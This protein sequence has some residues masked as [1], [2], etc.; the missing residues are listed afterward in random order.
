MNGGMRVLGRSAVSMIEIF[1][2]SGKETSHKVVQSVGFTAMARL[3]VVSPSRNSND[4]FSTLL[5]PKQ[6]SVHS[7]TPNV[8]ITG[9]ES[10]KFALLNVKTGEEIENSTRERSAHASSLQLSKDRT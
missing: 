2:Y 9:H 5:D 8:I 4:D 7:L 10:G 3:E 1:R 6:L